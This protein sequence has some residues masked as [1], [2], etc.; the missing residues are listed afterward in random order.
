MGLRAADEEWRDS[1]Q[2]WGGG[3]QGRFLHGHQKG[4][5]LLTAGSWTPALQFCG[6]T[7]L[8]PQVFGF[9]S[10]EI[11]SLRG[12]LKQNG[13]PSILEPSGQCRGLSAQMSWS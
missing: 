2:L 5:T 6:N 3:R 13:S 10:Q 12:P 9:W 7:V 11:N 1:H 4:P 8:S